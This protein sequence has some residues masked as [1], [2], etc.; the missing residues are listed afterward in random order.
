MG[1]GAARAASN[2]EILRKACGD[3]SS[4]F[5]LPWCPPT[6]SCWRGPCSRCHFRPV[7]APAPLTPLYRK[8]KTAGYDHMYTADLGEYNANNGWTQEGVRALVFTTQVPGSVKLYRLWSGVAID[9]LYTTDKS[10]GDKATQTGGYVYEDASLYVYPSAQCG[11]VPLYRLYLGGDGKDHFYTADP[12]ERDQAVGLGYKYEWVAGYVFPKDAAQQQQQQQ[13]QPAQT[14]TKG[15]PDPG[16]PPAQ[17]SRTNNGSPNAGSSAGGTTLAA[18]GGP[19][20]LTYSGSVLPAATSLL[21]GG[22]NTNANGDSQ[23]SA[24]GVRIGSG[25]SVGGLIALGIVCL[26]A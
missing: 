22:Q 6:L 9:H 19:G 16:A 2:A 18:G 20:L 10:E 7:R 5:L 11:A 13:Q 1:A 3:S 21:P 15:Q 26:I 25:V 23:N 12:A 8:Y 4:L 14:T 24:A 17:P